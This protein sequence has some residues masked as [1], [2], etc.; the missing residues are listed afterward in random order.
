MQTMIQE[1]K[2]IILDEIL[3]VMGTK[4]L[5]MNTCLIVNGYRDRFLWIWQA[6]FFPSIRLLN[7]IGSSTILVLIYEITQ[8]RN[9]FSSDIRGK[10]YFLF[11]F[12]ATQSIYIGFN[13]FQNPKTSQRHDETIKVTLNVFCSIKLVFNLSFSVKKKI[14]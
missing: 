3:R 5:H 12:T 13:D 2:S 9:S 7:K 10:V 11:T 8:R 4:T 14:K 6:A 1:E